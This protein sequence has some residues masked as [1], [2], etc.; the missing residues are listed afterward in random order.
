MES[1]TNKRSN[2]DLLLTNLSVQKI[3]SHLNV[4]KSEITDK[5]ITE[6]ISDI[7]FALD[8][9]LNYTFFN[10]ACEELTGILAKDVIKK[11]MLDIF[12]EVRGSVI[13]KSYN[14]AL[15]TNKPQTLIRDFPVGTKKMFFETYIYPTNTGISVFGKNITE[16]VKNELLQSALYKISQISNSGITLDEL[17][18][19]IHSYIGEIIDA[20]NFYIAL[21][22]RQNDMISFPYFVDEVDHFSGPYKARKG[23]TEYVIR[24]GKPL[25][26]DQ[27][28]HQELIKAGKVDLIGKPCK[29][30]LGV[31]LTSKT[32][33]A[34]YLLKSVSC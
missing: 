17:Y 25:L 34:F 21:Y 18:H 2:I 28:Q 8:K 19:S 33:Y 12:P 13:E 31:P 4:S 14:K 9:N 3:K 15:R 27:A 20:R 11:S 30:W 6:S 26:V 10:K 16:R 23:L 7:F 1:K 5:D 24:T 32:I 29:I 22:D